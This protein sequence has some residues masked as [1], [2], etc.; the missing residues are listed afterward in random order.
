MSKSK[1]VGIA[2]FIAFA[3]GI[4]LVG[5]ALAGREAT[6]NLTGGF[7][8]TSKVVAF[9]EN[10]IYGAGEAFGVWMGDT[11]KEMVHGASVHP[12]F[13]FQIEKGFYS[14]PGGVVWTLLNGD[15]IYLKYIT[16]AK[17]GE[18]PKGTI[19]ILGGTGK[20]AGIEGSGEYTMHPSV[21]SVEGAWQ[22]LCKMKIH[23]KLP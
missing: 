7:Y 6:E 13:F 16:S 11:G 20:C 12:V 1:I 5:D 17:P 3:M 19:N 21:P 2:V 18:T 22:G 23:Y 9:G 10:Y 15:K 8:G 4:L 14:E